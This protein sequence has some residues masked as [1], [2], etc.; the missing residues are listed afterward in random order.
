MSASCWNLKR[1]LLKRHSGLCV[2]YLSNARC[3]KLSPKSFI[4][5]RREKSWLYIAQVNCLKTNNCLREI[6]VKA[7]NW[8]KVVDKFCVLLRLL[9]VIIGQVDI[10]LPPV[11]REP[12]TW[13]GCPTEPGCKNS[14]LYGLK[15]HEL[16]NF[17]VF[18]KASWPCSCTRMVVYWYGQLGQTQIIINGIKY[19]S[20]PVVLLNTRIRE[21]QLGIL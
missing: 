11:K 8:G 14:N 16:Q 15:I 7:C 20:P 2:L 9:S 3:L 10:H 13:L 1:S 12:T 21:G 17:I 6:T 18:I 19:A 4:N 5:Y